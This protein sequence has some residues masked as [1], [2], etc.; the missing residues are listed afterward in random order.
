VRDINQNKEKIQYK[1]M[2]T[3]RLYL[4]KLAIFFRCEKFDQKDDFMIGD[5]LQLLNIP[6]IH[7]S[8]FHQWRAMDYHP[9]VN[10]KSIL[11]VIVAMDKKPG[12]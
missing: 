12:L 4:I 3:G 2:L 6:I 8:G 7:N 1:L 11:W 5:S 9:G 10:F